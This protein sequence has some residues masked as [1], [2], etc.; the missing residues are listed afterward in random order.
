MIITVVL[1]SSGNVYVT[2]Y[3]TIYA[4]LVGKDSYDTALD[5]LYHKEKT[6]SGPIGQYCVIECRDEMTISI[7]SEVTGRMRERLMPH[8]RYN[9]YLIPV[10]NAIRTVFTE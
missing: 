1:K 9:D 8:E 3:D 10:K 2:G 4:V 6:G 5:M 7:A